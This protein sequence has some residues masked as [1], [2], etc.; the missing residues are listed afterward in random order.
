MCLYFEHPQP[1][2]PQVRPSAQVSDISQRY[3]FSS[4]RTCAAEPRPI[5]S[6]HPLFSDASRP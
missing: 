2:F 5:L 1:P 6:T 3:A 4:D